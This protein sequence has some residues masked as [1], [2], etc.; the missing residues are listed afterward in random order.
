MCQATNLSGM[1][2]Y[3]Q[4]LSYNWLTQLLRLTQSL[5]YRFLIM[6]NRCTALESDL[7]MCVD[8][9]NSQMSSVLSK[10]Q[11]Q[12]RYLKSLYLKVVVA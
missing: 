9:V 7:K 6:T 4:E 5:A 2:E 11:H 10:R 12:V 1:L 3:H 8:G